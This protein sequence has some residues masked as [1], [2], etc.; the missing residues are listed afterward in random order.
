MKYERLQYSGINFT[1]YTIKIITT[2]ELK[3]D[4]FNISR[5][6]I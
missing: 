5:D 1:N 3:C 6:I 2:N 4:P